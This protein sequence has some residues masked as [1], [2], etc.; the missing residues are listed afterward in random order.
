MSTF[1][2]ILVFIIVASAAIGAVSAAPWLP[3]RRGDVSRIMDLAQV[4][5]GDV[6][7]DLGCGDGRLVFAAA[8]RGARAIGVEVFVLPYL[9]AKVKSFFIPRSKI[10]FGDL[11]RQDISDASVVCIFLL[12]KSYPRLIE[13]FRKELTSGSRVVTAAW[14]LREIS[15]DIID[16]PDSKHLSLFL[17]RFD[18]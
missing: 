4:G 11:F 2:F 17:Y 3:T 7:Y 18:R 12:D 15:A 5:P 6:V 14:P 16:K 9:W 13:K 8:R 10:V 1:L